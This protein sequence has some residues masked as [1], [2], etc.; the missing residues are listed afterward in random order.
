MLCSVMYYLVV[1]FPRAICYTGILL[2]IVNK[3]VHIGLRIKNKQSS[4]YLSKT[5]SFPC[6]IKT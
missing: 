6:S 5:H 1:S 4:G 2:K 3:S